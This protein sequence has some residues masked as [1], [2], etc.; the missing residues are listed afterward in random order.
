MQ[1]RVIHGFLTVSW[2][3]GSVVS[4]PPPYIV[5]RQMVYVYRYTCIM[6]CIMGS[7]WSSW[8]LWSPVLEYGSWEE[9]AQVH[10]SPHLAWLRPRQSA[11]F[12]HTVCLH[13]T[14]G[15]PLATPCTWEY[16]HRWVLS[17]F[18]TTDLRKTPR[19][20]PAGSSGLFG[21]KIQGSQM[22]RHI[23]TND[24]VFHVHPARRSPMPSYPCA[25]TSCLPLA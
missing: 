11:G 25:S 17:T 15:L 12:I 9:L 14:N 3:G 21:Q 19:Q 2:W 5:Q 10:C 20:A 22:H 4:T 23:E 24:L 8:I 6:T 7:V 16:T 13:P 1:G 18:R